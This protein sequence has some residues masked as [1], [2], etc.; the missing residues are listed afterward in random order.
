[1]FNY[2][3]GRKPRYDVEQYFVENKP[4]NEPLYICNK[5]VVNNPKIYEFYERICAGQIIELVKGF[6]NG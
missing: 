5:I 6:V 3:I 2:Y 1:M 4:G